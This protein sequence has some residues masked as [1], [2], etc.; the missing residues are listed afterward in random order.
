M[1][2]AV[3]AYASLWAR[4]A[5][6]PDPTAVQQVG[7][8]HLLK[9]GMRTK[10]NFRQIIIAIKKSKSNFPCAVWHQKGWRLCDTKTLLVNYVDW[11]YCNYFTAAQLQ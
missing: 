7:C 8:D 3:I 9:V 2:L 6:A 10:Q 4:K 11:V 5:C 1:H